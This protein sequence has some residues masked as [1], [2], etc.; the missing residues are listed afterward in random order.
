[1]HRFLIINEREIR[2]QIPGIFD[3]VV[4][5]KKINNGLWHHIVIAMSAESLTLK[6]V[7]DGRNIFEEKKEY[8]S[9]LTFFNESGSIVIGK[10][11]TN[12]E[13][14]NSGFIGDISQ[15]AL[16]NRV[17]NSTEIAGLVSNC[18]ISVNGN[19]KHLLAIFTLF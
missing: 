11:L 15:L 19:N 2:I 8:L 5:S 12:G 6:V 3:F 14:V 13:L 1:M 9:G 16:W 4:L 7:L 18:S 10:S 17:L